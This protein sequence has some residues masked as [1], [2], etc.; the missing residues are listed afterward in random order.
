MGAHDQKYPIQQSSGID[1]IM[2]FAGRAFQNMKI[3]LARWEEASD[4]SSLGTRGIKG[5]P[6]LFA[7]LAAPSPTVNYQLD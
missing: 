4:R 6:Q 5:P 3:Q 7:R 1:R 2:N